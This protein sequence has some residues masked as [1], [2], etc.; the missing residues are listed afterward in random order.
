MNLLRFGRIRRVSGDPA[1]GV[2]EVSCDRHQGVCLCSAST[3][4]QRKTAYPP[5][6]HLLSLVAF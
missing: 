1:T 6:V 4:V 2:V 5:S 3:L